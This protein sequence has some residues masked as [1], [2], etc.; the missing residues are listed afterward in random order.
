MHLHKSVQVSHAS[1][2]GTSALLAATIFWALSGASSV[3]HT[4]MA[5]LAAQKTPAGS[6]LVSYPLSE[7]SYANV[8]PNVCTA[9]HALLSYLVTRHCHLLHSCSM[10]HVSKAL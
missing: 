10:H 2:S 9:Q 3:V 6:K 4:V 8:C 5:L 7:F 1:A